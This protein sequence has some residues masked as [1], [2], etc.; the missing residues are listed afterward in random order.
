MTDIVTLLAEALHG[1]TEVCC[2]DKDPCPFCTE[3]ARKLLAHCPPGLI[4]TTVEGLA[5][6]LETNGYLAHMVHRYGKA[7]DAYWQQCA[8]ELAAAI[9]EADHGLA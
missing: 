3:T 8:N 9:R 7:N 1:W 2:G 5:G 4:I 6:A